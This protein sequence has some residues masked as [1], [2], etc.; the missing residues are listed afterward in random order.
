LRHSFRSQPQQRQEFRQI[1]QTFRL[2]SLAHSQRL[3]RIL[4]IQQRLQA[5]GNRCG[6]PEPG[7]FAWQI[8]IDGQSHGNLQTL[9]M[10]VL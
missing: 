9:V 10:P 7:Q 6:E 4:A 2:I 1:N 3:A 5:R 8:D